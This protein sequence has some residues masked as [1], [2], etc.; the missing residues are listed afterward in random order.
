MKKPI[1]FTLFVGI[2]LVALTITLYLML[3]RNDDLDPSDN[4]ESADNQASPH[5]VI[6]SQ[7]QGSYVMNEIQKGARS[8]A[9]SHGMLIDFW[10]VYRSNVEELIKQVDIAIASKVDG[11]IIEGVDRPD[12]VQ[13]INKATFRGIPVVMI[14]SDAPGSLRKTYVGSDHYQEGIVMGKH[15]AQALN[16]QGIIGVVTNM[17]S[18]DTDKLRQRGLRE[19]LAQYKGIQLVYASKDNEHVQANAQTNDILNHY[20]KVNAFIGLPTE[21][22]KSI[23]QAG[24]SRSRTHG[25][26]VFMFDNSPQTVKLIQDGLIESGLSQ[27]YEEMGQMS[28]DLMKRWLDSEQLPL[29][30]RYFTPIS[31]VAASADGG[32]AK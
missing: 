28:V 7:E 13:I 4:M 14:N 27:H 15:I 26:D 21:S 2:C 25:Y 31:V 22:G 32:G 5:I 12:F 16:G 3:Y 29:N 6:I 20:P 8:A 18:S 30:K 10:G 9:A 19:V 17:E 1:F 23:V 11:I 24:D